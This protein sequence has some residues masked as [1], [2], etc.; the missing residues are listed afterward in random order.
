MTP[1]TFDIKFPLN[2]QFTFGSLTFTARE[3][4]DLNMLPLGPA[5]EHPAPVPLST[6]GGACSGLDPFTELYIR[7]AK[8][9]R[10]ISIVTSILPPFTGASSLSSSAKD[11]HIILMVAP[12]EDQSCNSQWIS[13]YWDIIGI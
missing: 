2:T 12:N 1:W 5:P 8:L 3:D 4:R 13:H 9:V 10:S 6:S 7:T 11:D